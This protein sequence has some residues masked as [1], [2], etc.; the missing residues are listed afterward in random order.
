M[1]NPNICMNGDCE[2]LNPGYRC[3]CHPGFLMEAQDRI[4]IGNVFYFLSDKFITINALIILNCVFSFNMWNLF[5]Q[6][7]SML[8][9]YLI[10]VYL[11]TGI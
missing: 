1:Q 5:N 10:V 3:K 4:C 8:Y 11:Q 6:N 2:N 9:M 7:L